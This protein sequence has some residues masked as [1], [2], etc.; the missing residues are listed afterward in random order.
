[1]RTHIANLGYLQCV[2]GARSYTVSEDVNLYD[3]DR[4]IVWCCLF[5]FMFSTAE[6]QQG[7]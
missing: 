1:M 5:R 3:V 4:V 2:N 7:S 6:F